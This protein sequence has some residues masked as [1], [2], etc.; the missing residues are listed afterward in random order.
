MTKSPVHI[1]T[2]SGKLEGLRAINSDPTTNLFCLQ[3]NRTTKENQICGHC[4]SLRMLRSYRKNCQPA[5]E[6]NNKLFSGRV[7][8]GLPKFKEG[9]YVRWNGHGELVGFEHYSWCLAI[10]R[11]NPK[12]T[13]A[14]WTK[15]KKLVQDVHNAY[16]MRPKNLILIYSNPIIDDVMNQPPTWFDKVFNNVSEDHP[17]ENCTGQKCKDCLLC[18]SK[19][20]TDV[21]VEHVK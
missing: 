9:E 18:Y 21:I 11:A 17:D 15:Q 20:T 16:I 10:A 7:Q 1:S 12:T 14:L 5:F 8:G 19:D 3:M 13:F 6:R 4:Y 2:M